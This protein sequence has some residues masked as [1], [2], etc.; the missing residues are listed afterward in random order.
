MLH[1]LPSS[2]HPRAAARAALD[3]A[4]WISGPVLLTFSDV[5]DGV[6]HKALVVVVKHGTS[7]DAVVTA[8][9]EEALK[10]RR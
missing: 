2:G 6:A 4:A 7:V 5:L 9:R 1:N 10:P 3:L 8:L